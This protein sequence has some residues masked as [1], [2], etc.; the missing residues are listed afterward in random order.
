MKKL[1]LAFFAL[2]L[3]PVASFAGN[4]SGAVS[5]IGAVQNG[6]VVF[7]TSS[8]TGAPVCASVALDWA[9]NTSTA[10]GKAI[11]ALVLTAINQGKSI[12]VTGNNTCDAW[13]DRETA[14]QVWVSP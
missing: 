11:Y 8:H 6:I 13:P 2:M 4:G 3:L 5:Q 14:A 10:S 12:S 7:K 1:L 9:I